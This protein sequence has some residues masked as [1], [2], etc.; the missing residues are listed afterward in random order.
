[1][2]EAADHGHVGLLRGIPCPRLVAEQVEMFYVR[3]DEDQPGIVTGF[4]EIAALGEEAVARVDGVASRRP[5]RGDHR[6]HIEI[7]RG[8][9]P[10]Q[11]PDFVGDAKVQAAR[12]VL[13]VN[14]N[15]RQAHVGGGARNADGDFAA[16]GDQEP[17]DFHAPFL[18]KMAHRVKRG[19]GK[20]KAHYDP[21]L[22]HKF[23]H[24]RATSGRNPAARSLASRDN[25]KKNT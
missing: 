11:Q 14:R 25:A 19:G 13:G 3:T 22:V 1:M 6:L 16:I 12:V 18:I 8:A 24:A 10:R 23:R 15:R 7:G 5:R 4:G 9:R 17:C 20:L 21:V 2:I